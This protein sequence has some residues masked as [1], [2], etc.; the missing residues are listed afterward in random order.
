MIDTVILRQLL[1]VVEERLKKGKEE[2]EETCAGVEL[3][4]LDGMLANRREMGS[5]CSIFVVN[6]GSQ[7]SEMRGRTERSLE[8]TCIL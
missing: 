8:N 4:A 2:E 6:F 7:L 5:N 3:E 1:N